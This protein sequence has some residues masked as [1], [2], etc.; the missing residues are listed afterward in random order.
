MYKP[1]SWASDVKAKGDAKYNPPWRTMLSELG[2]LYT[3]DASIE[4]SFGMEP[5]PDG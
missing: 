3:L 5:A 1:V 4:T 2:S